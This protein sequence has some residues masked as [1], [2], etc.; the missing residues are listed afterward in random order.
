MEIP[1]TYSAE[2]IENIKIEKTKE[3]HA[4][5]IDDAEVENELNRI[6]R[7]ELNLRAKLNDNARERHKFKEIRDKS[8]QRKKDLELQI[9]ILTQEYW[10]RRNGF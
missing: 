9:K 5:E 2:D 8:R 6:R 1:A 4:A 3:L 10:K 7:D